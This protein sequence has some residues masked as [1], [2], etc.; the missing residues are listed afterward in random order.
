V[1]RRVVVLFR[2]QERDPA[3]TVADRLGP[4]TWLVSA[5]ESVG[6]T[7]PDGHGFHP[8]SPPSHS[9]RPRGPARR[10]LWA[11]DCSKTHDPS[12]AVDS[13]PGVL[14][15]APAAPLTP[16]R[17]CEHQAAREAPRVRS[18]PPRRIPDPKAPFLH[19]PFERRPTGCH[20]HQGSPRPGFGYPLREDR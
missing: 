2:V 14:R 4:P 15:P 1:G 19:P 13:H 11:P 9:C 6:P 20:A 7:S 16:R 10:T 8:P 18:L 17:P 5:S 3:P 12:P